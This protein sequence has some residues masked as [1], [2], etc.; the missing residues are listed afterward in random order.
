MMIPLGILA[1]G[2]LFSKKARFIMKKIANL[3]ICFIL[4]ITFFCFPAV[5]AEEVAQTNVTWEA[6]GHTLYI[7]GKGDMIIEYEFISQIPWYY[8]RTNITKIVIGEGI[9]SIYNGAFAD[10]R[11]VKEVVFPNSLRTIGP[12][13]FI[14]CT[15]LETITLPYKITE[16][17]DGAFCN[18]S[19]LKTITIPG[20]ILEISP[21]AFYNCSNVTINGVT[22]TYTEAFALENKI[23]FLGGLAPSS[24][25]LVR[26]NGEYLDFDQKPEIVN[27]R[28]LVPVRAIFESMG[29]NVN[30][31]GT[32]R[33]VSASRG[34]TSITMV[35]DTNVINKNTNGKKTSVE[36]DVPAQ[37]LGNRTMVPA[38]AVS[39]S[40]GASVKW[41]A[42]TRT[43]IITD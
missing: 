10:F 30:W 22:G 7:N 32:T 17:M 5:H 31:D 41:D 29:I 40:F 42:L 26:V 12:A 13:A 2:N 9:T 43:V 34:A 36:I 23:N 11:A 25:I 24:E 16:I 8:L 15:S 6:Q 4:C 19:S 1:K 28:T 20:S 18:C 3:F 38:R 14:T 27:G 37:I 33:T 39:E 35:I 21:D